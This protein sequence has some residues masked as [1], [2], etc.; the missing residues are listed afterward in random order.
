MKVCKCP[1]DD[2]A[3]GIHYNECP[4]SHP[5]GGTFSNVVEPSPITYEKVKA[6]YDEMQKHM[7]SPIVLRPRVD[8]ISP[9]L[10]QELVDQCVIDESGNYRPP[11]EWK[12]P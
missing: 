11:S 7:L 10:F 2:V 3:K 12:I 6:A 9:A 4:T 8:V 1:L 5:S